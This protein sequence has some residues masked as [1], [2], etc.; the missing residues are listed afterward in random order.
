M[1]EE[2]E[3]REEIKGRRDEGDGGRGPGGGA[4]AR[5][6]GRG[7]ETA[8]ER[9]PPHLISPFNLTALKGVMTDETLYDAATLWCS[10]ESEAL[11]IHGHISTWH[12]SFIT[13]TKGLFSPGKYLHCLN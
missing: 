6:R 3:V 9:T 8:R 10:D 13:T 12:T 1:H 5:A 11:T 4:K 2:G 7:R